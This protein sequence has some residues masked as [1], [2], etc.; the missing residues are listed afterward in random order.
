MIQGGTLSLNPGEKITITD[1]ACFQQN[2]P[3]TSHQQTWEN[4][5][6]VKTL[7]FVSA[8][9]SAGSGIRRQS[10]R[11]SGQRKSADSVVFSEPRFPNG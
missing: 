3:L 1:Q 9:G 5:K 4:R 7:W 8:K 6:K 10:T 11:I 2:V